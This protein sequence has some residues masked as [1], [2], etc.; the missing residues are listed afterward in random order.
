MIAINQRKSTMKAFFITIPH[1]GER[2]PAET[3]WLQGLPEPILMADVDRYVDRLYQPVI[4][5]LNLQYVK[6]EWHR[7]VVDLNRFP[8]DVD[9]DSVIGSQNPSGKFTRGLHW[10]KTM[11]GEVLMPKPISEELHAQLVKRYFD[12]FHVDVKAVYKSIF[13]QGAKK[14][15]HLD[16]HSMPSIGTAGHRDPGERRADV[17]VSDWDDRSCEKSYMDLVCDAYAA[18]GLS[19]KVNWPYV[20]GRVTEAYGKP[21]IGQHAIQVE[22]NRALYMDEDSKKLIP[23][24][25]AALT[26]KITQAVR[27][28]YDNLPDL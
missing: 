3:P 24:K 14:V 18:T 22:L 5:D 2:F 23:D 1:S 4:Q 11:K 19:V 13:A 20:G 12:P 16:A 27:H 7:Y 17:V 28:I 8:S 10:V 15:Y 6:T 9:A 25:A 21:E 26:L